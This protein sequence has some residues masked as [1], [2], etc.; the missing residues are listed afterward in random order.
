VVTTVVD[1]DVG[2][3]RLWQVVC[4][5]AATRI[6]LFERHDL[7]AASKTGLSASTHSHLSLG[8]SSSFEFNQ[9]VLDLLVRPCRFKP[10]T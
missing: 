3:G 4:C 9:L 2:C 5:A 8:D 1:R 6:T 10:G 7:L